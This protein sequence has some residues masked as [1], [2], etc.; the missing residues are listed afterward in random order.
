[1]DTLTNLII[2]RE[3][4][5]RGTLG[6]LLDGPHCALGH[7]MLADGLD[8]TAVDVGSPLT[9]WPRAQ[10]DTGRNWASHVMSVNDDEP[11]PEVREAELITLFAEQGITLEFTGTYIEEYG[12]D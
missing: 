11:D 8:F 1:M 4:W 7:C 9:T 3:K 5:C 12:D 6:Y 10:K 2:P